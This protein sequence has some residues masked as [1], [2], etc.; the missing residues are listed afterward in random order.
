MLNHI[1]S[2]ITFTLKHEL[3]CYSE[4]VMLFYGTNSIIQDSRVTIFANMA[5][6]CGKDSLKDV[7]ISLQET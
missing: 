1:R 6:L 5:L 4:N 3:K 2:Q 7:Y